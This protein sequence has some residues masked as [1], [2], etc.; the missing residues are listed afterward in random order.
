[1]SGMDKITYF[2]SSRKRRSRVASF[3]DEPDSKEILNYETTHTGHVLIL[4]QILIYF[5]QLIFT[6]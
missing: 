4:L 6:I 1:M 3:D 2:L 5:P